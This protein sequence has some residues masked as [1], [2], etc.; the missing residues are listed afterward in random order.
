MSRTLLRQATYPRAIPIETNIPKTFEREEMGSKD[1]VQSVE[2]DLENSSKKESKQKLTTYLSLPNTASYNTFSRRVSGRSPASL[3]SP[4]GVERL[5][6]TATDLRKAAII[7]VSLGALACCIVTGLEL[8]SDED[9]NSLRRG[10]PLGVGPSALPIARPA[11]PNFIPP[12]GGIVGWIAVFGALSMFGSVGIMFKEPPDSSGSRPDPVLF[13]AFNALGIFVI[14]VPMIVYEIQQQLLSGGSNP[15]EWFDWLGVIGAV[16]I[17]IVSF[18]ANLST[19][20]IGYAMAPAILNGVGMVTSF[21]IGKLYFREEINNPIGATNSLLILVAGVGLLAITNL[22]SLYVHQEIAAKE[23]R[24]TEKYKL[25]SRNSNLDS[26]LSSNS[27]SNLKSNSKK[28]ETSQ[29]CCRFSKGLWKVIFGLLAGMCAGIFDG[30]LMVPYKIHETTNGNDTRNTLAYLASFSA[31]TLLSFPFLYAFAAKREAVAC[32]TERS[33]SERMGY[34]TAQA[35]IPGMVTGFVWAMGNFLSV[36]ATKHLG[37]SVGFPLVQTGILVAAVWGV[38]FF[39]DIDVSRNR[40]L[41]PFLAGLL[42]LICGAA[43]LAR[44]G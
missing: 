7:V 5:P 34:K 30:A 38:F 43:A 15:F 12:N 21:I 35:F 32:G 17:I 9:K 39:K 4:F 22:Q 20:L 11:S 19:Q 25:S 42:A 29:K 27:N 16:D 36:H 1:Q 33:W 37:M 31:G 8:S 23:R 40:V 14:G 18:W 28:K 10:V 41:A 26:N 13:Q 44:F 2:A 6:Y 3:R 24:Q